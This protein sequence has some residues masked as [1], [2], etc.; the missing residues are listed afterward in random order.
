MVSRC[1]QI[2]GGG[3]CLARSSFHFLFLH[4]VSFGWISDLLHF[5][6]AVFLSGAISE[7]AYLARS[8]SLLY[9]YP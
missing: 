4:G 6:L 8:R 2:I 7:H 1:L 9:V 3:L 5:S